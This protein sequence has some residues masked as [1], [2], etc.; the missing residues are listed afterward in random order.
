MFFSDASKKYMIL[1]IEGNSASRKEERKMTQFSALL[2]ENQAV[3]EVNMMNRNVNYISPYVQ[4]LT[5]ISLKKC[6]NIGLSE[7]HL[8]KEIYR[9]Y[10][11]VDII[12]AYGYDFDRQ[13]LHDMFQKYHFPEVN[14]TWI[15]VQ[16]IVKEKLSPKRLRLACVAKEFGFEDSHFHNALVDCHATLFL[17][18]L[19]EGKEQVTV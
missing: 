6:K 13:I 15:D 5:H 2:I 17:M 10:K 7:R 11:E 8:I 12:Y 18:R 19:I 4:H 14:K 9:L 1:D 3:R 16:P